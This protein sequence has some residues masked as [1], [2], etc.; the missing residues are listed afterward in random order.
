MKCKLKIE[1]KTGEKVGYIITP[2]DTVVIDGAYIKVFESRD[3]D[4]TVLTKIP[5][6]EVKKIKITEVKYI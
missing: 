2:V 3:D 4:S 1:F 6:D 5:W